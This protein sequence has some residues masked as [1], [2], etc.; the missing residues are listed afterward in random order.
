LALFA[1]DLDIEFPI[2]NIENNY[3]FDVNFYGKSL[4]HLFINHMQ[5]Y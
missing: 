3:C 5:P 1:H 2:E 4:T